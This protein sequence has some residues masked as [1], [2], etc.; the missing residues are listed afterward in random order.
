M[1]QIK[2][3]ILFFFFFGCTTWHAGSQFHNQ[4]WN[5]C[6]LQQKYR[7]ITTGSPGKSLKCLSLINRN[8]IR[9]LD[10]NIR[11]YKTEKKHLQNPKEK[12]FLY[13]NSILRDNCEWSRLSDMKSVKP[14]LPCIFPR[15]F[16]DINTTKTRG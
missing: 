16:L 9:Y 7:I 6:P 5:P 1:F 2:C 13:Y 8:D 14:H 10:S 12:L 15:K 11:I 4:G 3:L